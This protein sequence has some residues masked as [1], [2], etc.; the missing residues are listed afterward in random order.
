MQIT[1]ELSEV[2]TAFLCALAPRGNAK[3]ANSL[4]QTAQR[5]L[6]DI[7]RSEA[8]RRRINQHRISAIALAE[9]V[10]KEQ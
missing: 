5:L 8:R 4:Q 3:Q 7:M 9:T 10:R 6:A 1:L 2:D